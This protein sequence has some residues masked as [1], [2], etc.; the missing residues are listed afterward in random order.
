MKISVVLELVTKRERLMQR[1]AAEM[2]VAFRSAKVAALR[3]VNG[4]EATLFHSAV[5]SGC[6]ERHIVAVWLRH[7]ELAMSLTSEAGT[8]R[9]KAM[10]VLIVSA[11]FLPCCRR[12]LVFLLPGRAS[13]IHS[14]SVVATQTLDE[15]RLYRRD[16]STHQ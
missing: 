1:P 8:S 14:V 12:W 13:V 15:D 2:I 5:L 6:S 10:L 3:T 4:V 16:E 9:S 11:S 7:A